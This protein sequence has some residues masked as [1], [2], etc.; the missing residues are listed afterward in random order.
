MDDLRSNVYDGQGG[1]SHGWDDNGTW[2]PGK[3]GQWPNDTVKTVTLGTEV[4]RLRM[5]LS[6]ARRQLAE[7]QRA[8]V[9][10]KDMQMSF[11]AGA[12]R[13]IA[14]EALR[15]LHGALT[16]LSDIPPA[17]TPK[18]G[19]DDGNAKPSAAQEEGDCPAGDPLWLK[20]QECELL[21]GQLAEAQAKARA[22]TSH[23]MSVEDDLLTVGRQLAEAKARTESWIAYSQKQDGRYWRTADRAAGLQSQVKQSN[24]ALSA[25]Q[26]KLWNAESEVVLLRAERNAAREQL[27]EARK[28]VWLLIGLCRIVWRHHPETAMCITPGSLWHGLPRWLRKEIER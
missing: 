10:I 28:I 7:A 17:D 21:Q 5:D 27:A 19:A 8:L 11:P 4:D 6:E 1:G 12:C 16:L 22:E 20:T 24:D 25:A 13:L 2:Y 18:P 14:V 23:S 15:P 3:D 26:K 9:R